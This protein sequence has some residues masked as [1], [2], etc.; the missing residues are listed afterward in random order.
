MKKRKIFRE[1]FDGFDFIEIAEYSDGDV[2][3][4]L[5]YPGMIRL[6]RKIKAIINNAKRIID[7]RNKYGSF[8]NYLWSYSK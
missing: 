6:E 8:D 5:D 7:I 4:I 1:C 2:A 3:R